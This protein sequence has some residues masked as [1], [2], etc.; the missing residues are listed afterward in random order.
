MIRMTISRDDFSVA[1]DRIRKIDYQKIINNNLTEIFNRG[2]DRGTPKNKG[3][4]PFKTGELRMSLGKSGDEVG[5]DKDYAPHVEYGHR[6]KNGGYV[7]GQHFLQLNADAQRKTYE[8]DV[9]NAIKDA[10]E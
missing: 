4:T 9:L 2:K 10:A 3:R 5:Y 7:E 1:A 6:T 8:N